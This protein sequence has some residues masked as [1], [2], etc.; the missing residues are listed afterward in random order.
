MKK[1]SIRMRKKKSNVAK[2]SLE[3]LAYQSGDCLNQ[4]VFHNKVENTIIMDE[5]LNF[6]HIQN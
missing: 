4:L 6:M 2:R 3:I 1:R 5:I